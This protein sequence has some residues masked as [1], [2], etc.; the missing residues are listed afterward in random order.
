MGIR[1]RIATAAVANIYIDLI[2]TWPLNGFCV[3]AGWCRT[4]FVLCIFHVLSELGASET[5]DAPQIVA[6]IKA[7][8]SQRKHTDCGCS[9]IAVQSTVASAQ[10]GCVPSLM[11][12]WMRD[13]AI[14]ALLAFRLV[15]QTHRDQKL[16]GY[17]VIH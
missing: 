17:F 3:A 15:K 7:N 11:S 4:H 8:D 14:S 10:C 2:R 9:R 12:L 13:A 1:P 5:M 16:L 6:A